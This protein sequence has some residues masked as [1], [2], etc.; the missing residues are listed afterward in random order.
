MLGFLAIRSRGVS[1]TLSVP[2]LLISQDV[3]CVLCVFFVFLFGGTIQGTAESRFPWD[4]LVFSEFGTS[5]S[6]LKIWG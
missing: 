3:L 4:R 2:D 1:V 6:Q 5:W